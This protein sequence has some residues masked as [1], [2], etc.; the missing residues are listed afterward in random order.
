MKVKNKTKP[1]PTKNTPKE[2]EKQAQH[3]VPVTQMP[4]EGASGKGLCSRDDS[5][6]HPCLLR[7]LTAPQPAPGSP[8]LGSSAAALSPDLPSQQ[9]RSISLR[10]PR[11]LRR[12]PANARTS[13][14]RSRN[15]QP[16]KGTLLAAP[17]Y[18]PPAFF[19]RCRGLQFQ[20]QSSPDP[21]QSE[22]GSRGIPGARRLRANSS[23]QERLWAH[24]TEPPLTNA[25]PFQRPPAPASKRLRF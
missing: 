2:K 5:W 21:S 25:L 11:R 8:V 14:N 24:R 15:S 6:H 12:G 13:S 17:S 20:G 1:K 23:G 22:E 19:P 7:D 10:A 3:F 9:T 18:T 4:C 16:G